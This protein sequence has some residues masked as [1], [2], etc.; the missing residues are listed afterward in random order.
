M[1]RK[2]SLAGSQPRCSQKMTTKYNWCPRRHQLLPPKHSF[3]HSTYVCSRWEFI[4]LRV[5]LIRYQSVVHFMLSFFMFRDNLE[6][7]CHSKR[8]TK[9]CLESCHIL[10]SPKQPKSINTKQPQLVPIDLK[11]RKAV[12][13][14]SHRKHLAALLLNVVCW[15]NREISCISQPHCF[16]PRISTFGT[17][18]VR[19]CTVAPVCGFSH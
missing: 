19:N 2:F 1:N 14:R 10:L 5:R 16:L 15:T 7:H 11:C 17:Y 3:V 6:S 9:T 18:S 8:E 4:V 13:T 12:C